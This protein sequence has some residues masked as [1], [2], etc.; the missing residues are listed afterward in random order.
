MKRP[1]GCVYL[2]PL[3]AVSSMLRSV[4]MVVYNDCVMMGVVECGRNDGA[5]MERQILGLVSH[6]VISAVRVSGS[7]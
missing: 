4:M 1:M 5:S 7:P 2:R 6:C 3:G